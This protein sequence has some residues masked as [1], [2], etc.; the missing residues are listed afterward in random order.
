MA[1]SQTYSYKG[2]A[3]T[4]ADPTRITPAECLALARCGD[5]AWNSWRQ[6]FPGEPL[7]EVNVASFS[8]VD[9]TEEDIDFS[10]FR[11]DGVDFSNAVF[12][13]RQKFRHCNFGRANFSNAN[14]SHFAYFEGSVFNTSDFE[15]VEFLKLASFNSTLFGGTT[16][17]RNC[18]FHEQANFGGACIT[19]DVYFDQSKFSKDAYFIGTLFGDS[20]SFICC[21]FQGEAVFDGRPIETLRQVFTKPPYSFAWPMIESYVEKRG[22]SSMHFCEMDFNGVHFKDR[23]SFRSRSF[24]ARTSFDIGRQLRECQTKYI[25]GREM[26]E[27][28]YDLRPVVFEKPPEFFDSKFCQQISFDHA[29]FPAS[30]GDGG[31]AR[32]YRVLKQAFAAQQANREEQRFF[33]LEMA[34]EARMAWSL[35]GLMSTWWADRGRQEKTELPPARLIYKLYAVLSDFGFSIS[36]PAGLFIVSLLTAAGLYGWQ[37]GLTV[38]WHT[39]AACTATGSLAQFTF[40][41]AL[42]GLEKLAEPASEALF[43]HQ[44]GFWTVL[45]VVLHKAVSLLALFLIGLAL[46]NLFKMK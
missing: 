22:F 23:V 28:I 46:R 9:F 30:I 10:G 24:N 8:G 1:E 41:H 26:V 33:R 25:D 38:C 39:G 31:A 16:R 42:P 27:E 4:I 14:F 40:A 32:C 34:E 18:N 45:T 36:R 43:G 15:G 13:R 6:E 19:G 20:A 5:G 11:F 44:L 17:F 12:G 3:T 21:D 2:R 35:R 37:A 7:R 29:R